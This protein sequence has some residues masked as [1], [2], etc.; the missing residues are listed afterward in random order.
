MH[1]IPGTQR[2]TLIKKIKNLPLINKAAA[3]RTA[4]LKIT[5]GKLRHAA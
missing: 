2:L 5:F 1:R 4:A 3:L